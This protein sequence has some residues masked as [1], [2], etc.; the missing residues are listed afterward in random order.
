MAMTKL[1]RRRVLHLSAAAPFL[2]PLAM[3][4]RGAD[5]AFAAEE[6]PSRTVRFIVPTPPG[7]LLDLLPRMIG[8][9]LSQRWGQSVVV[10]NHTGAEQILGADYVSRADPDGYTLLFTPPGPIVLEQWLGTKLAFDPAAFVPVTVLA[11]VPNVLVVNGGA[12]FKTFEEWLAYAKANPGKLNY[13]SPG[14]AA[15]LAQAE[16]LRRLGIELVHIPYQGMAPAIND[17]VAGHIQMM[18]AAVGTILPHIKSGEVRPIALTGTESLPQLPNV[19]LVSQFVADYK[20]TVWF[21]VVAPPHTPDPIATTLWQGIADALNS[22]DIASRLQD[23]VLIKVANKP[24][25][26]AA[27]I[28]SE[29]ERWRAIVQ[30][31]Q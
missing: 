12:P 7:T 4:G 13:G 14:G 22:P 1:S 3:L 29:R 23:S 8:D 20:D 9:K 11:F 31:Q 19:P 10:E 5:L 21:A 17:L 24:A 18:S 2:G 30:A 26:A 25:E 15:Q 28:Q 16:L 27:F 6:F